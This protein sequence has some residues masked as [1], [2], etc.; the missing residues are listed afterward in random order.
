MYESYTW[1]LLVSG[2]GAKQASSW[3]K[4]VGFWEAFTLERCGRYTAR[5]LLR[6]IGAKAD[7][8]LGEKL[9]AIHALG[10]SVGNLTPRQVA[11]KYF[12]GTI[13][14]RDLNEQHVA[15]LDA[16]PFIAPTSARF[17]IRNMGGELIKDDRWLLAVMSYFHCDQ[18]ALQCAGEMLDWKLGRVDLVLWWYCEQEIKATQRL[19]AHF[20]AHGFTRQR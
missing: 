16:L 13:C 12:S 9:H 8:K 17:M 18:S 11:D 7:N 6:K 14:S 10:R 2:I 3:A 5:A 20:T 1:A 15:A 19:P 4:R